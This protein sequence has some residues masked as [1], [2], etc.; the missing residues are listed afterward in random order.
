MLD[1]QQEMLDHV[2]CYRAERDGLATIRPT[3]SDARELLYADGTFDAVYA[4]TAL[5]EIPE[6]DRVLREAARVLAQGG[7]W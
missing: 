5:G 1:I 4:V 3:R 6:P 7:G 2:M